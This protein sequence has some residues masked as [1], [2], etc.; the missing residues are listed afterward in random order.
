MKEVQVEVDIP[1]LRRFTRRDLFAAVALHAALSKGMT[2][3]VAVDI[4]EKSA[5]L[6]CECLPAE[7]DE[8]AA[9]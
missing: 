3:R 5:R 8:T 4:A 9:G 6:L 2:H 1:E 7:V